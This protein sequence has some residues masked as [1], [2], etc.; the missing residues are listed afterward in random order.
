V[1]TLHLTEAQLW[2]YRGMVSQKIAALRKELDEKTLSPFIVGAV[3]REIEVLYQLID[4]I[5]G[6]RERA[7][8]ERRGE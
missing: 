8:G 5:D 1:I 4:V 7:K 6:A 2:Q 3:E